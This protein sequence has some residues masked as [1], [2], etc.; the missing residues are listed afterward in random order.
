VATLGAKVLKLVRTAIGAIQIDGLEMGK[1][2]ALTKDEVRHLH[3]SR[4]P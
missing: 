4:L 2:R 1:W 3:E